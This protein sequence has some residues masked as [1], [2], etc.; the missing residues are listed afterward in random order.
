MSLRSFLKYVLVIKS[1]ALWQ[2]QTRYYSDTTMWL[3]TINQLPTINCSFTNPYRNCIPIHK[4]NV[5]HEMASGISV[6]L[7]IW[8]S[9]KIPSSDS[10][11]KQVLSHQTSRAFPLARRASSRIADVYRWKWHSIISVGKVIY[12]CCCIMSGCSCSGNRLR[13]ASSLHALFSC[14]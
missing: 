6:S 2:K 12:A 14:Y 3:P 5:C 7:S 9:I 8:S 11:L 1:G 13:G 10:V 4:L